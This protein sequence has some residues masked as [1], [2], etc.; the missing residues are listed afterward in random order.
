MEAA[1]DVT[2]RQLFGHLRTRAVHD[3][4]PDAEGDQQ[5]QILRQH[6][7]RT[8]GDEFTRDG[9]DEGL[10]TERVDVRRD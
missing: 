1:F 9:D 10:A 3:D 6:R 4:D 5:R 2:Q 8:G 7:Q